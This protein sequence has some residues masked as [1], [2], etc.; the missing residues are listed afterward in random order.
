MKF[1][2][3][4]QRCYINYFLT[5]STFL[6]KFS[7]YFLFPSVAKALSDTTKVV[8]FTITFTYVIS[9]AC[10]LTVLDSNDTPNLETIAA[11]ANMCV[12][13]QL[14]FVY[15][16]YSEW[17]TTDLLEIGDCFY[18]SPWYRLP[19]KQQKLLVLPVQQ[20]GQELRFKGLGLFDCSLVTFTTVFV[21]FK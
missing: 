2:I 21:L 13:F 8:L 1:V 9:I 19:S 12:V 17:I 20:A 11:L 15:F 16:Y 10:N 18:N 3:F 7:T 14:A 4:S 5:N 6:M